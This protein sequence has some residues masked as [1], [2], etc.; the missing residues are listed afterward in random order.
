MTNY[1]NLNL[2]NSFNLIHCMYVFKVFK[3]SGGI[4]KRNKKSPKP[5]RAS[6]A[7]TTPIDIPSVTSNNV[8]VAADTELSKAQTPAADTEKTHQPE[9]VK[10]EEG[11]LEL[12]QQLQDRV[13]SDGLSLDLHGSDLQDP[14]RY[15]AIFIYCD[16]NIVMTLFQLGG[17]AW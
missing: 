1:Q 11:Q 13:P 10:Q 4:S 15:C 3:R 8:P 7:T 6:F 17:N 12:D 14:T 9:E 16:I 5:K 2:G